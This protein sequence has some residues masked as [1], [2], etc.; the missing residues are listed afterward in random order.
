MTLY[1]EIIFLNQFYKGLWVVENVIPYYEPLIKPYTYQSHYYWSNFKIIGK[2]KGYRCHN[3]SVEEKQKLKGFDISKYKITS[4]RKDQILRNCV[5][6][7]AGES[8]F[9]MAFKI[10]QH[11][12][13]PN[14]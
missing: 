10:K 7:K 8:I 3:G 1:Q 6:P 4:A 13:K 11:T 9:N 14:L 12:L 5:E 2:E